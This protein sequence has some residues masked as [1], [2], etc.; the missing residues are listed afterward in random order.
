MTFPTESDSITA[1][2]E[3]TVELIRL[4]ISRTFPQLC[5][6]QKVSTYLLITFCEANM[7]RVRF[8]L[9]LFTFSHFILKEGLIYRFSCDW[10]DLRLYN[11]VVIRT[12]FK[13]KF[14]TSFS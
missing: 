5:I 9:D 8:V 11:A 1:D 14:K 10:C 7:S 12:F 4:D 6:F 3:S 13:T 2:R